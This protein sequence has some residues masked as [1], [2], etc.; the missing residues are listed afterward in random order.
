MKSWKTMVWAVMLLVMAGPGYGQAARTAAAKKV[1]FGTEYYTESMRVL[2]RM[3]DLR[4]DQIGKISA[5]AAATLRAGHKVVW[6]CTAGHSNIYEV[7]PSL[8]CLPKGGMISATEFSGQKATIDAL[9]KDDML[10]TNYINEQTVAA[11]SRGVYI[12][13]VTNSYFR[14]RSF[15]EQD[16]KDKK[17]NF[18]DMELEDISNEVLI[19]EVPGQVGLVSMPYIPEM[20]VGAGVGNFMIALYWYAVAEVADKMKNP[21]APSLRYATQYRDTVMKRLDSIMKTQKS[22]IWSTAEKLAVMVGNGSRMWV[23]STPKSVYCDAAGASMG[24]VFTNHFDMNKMKAGDILFVCEVSDS[25]NSVMAQEARAAKAKGAYIVGI[26]P[27]NQTEI[28]KLADE[29]FDNLSPEGYGLF[30]IPGHDNKI[31]LAGSLINSI[32][33]GAFQTQMVQ[34]MNERGW[35]PKYFMSYNWG[36]ASGGYFEWLSWS[37]NRVGF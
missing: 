3:W 11:H 14:H 23:H 12:V 13:G 25:T 5:R 9:G 28:K 7:E 2:N 22:R 37:V 21:D 18:K 8:P 4:K 15:S 33:Y 27:A 16:N 10:V 26:G 20:K 36:G 6:D 17:A 35:Y 24:L 31:A 29:Y 19:S 34:E 1:D 32:V 30:Q